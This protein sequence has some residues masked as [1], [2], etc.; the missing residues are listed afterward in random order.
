MRSALIA[1]ARYFI[2][3]LIRAGQNWSF[4][5]TFLHSFFELQLRGACKRIDTIVACLSVHVVECSLV[6]SRSHYW[7]AVLQMS[8]RYRTFSGIFGAPDSRKLFIIIH[9]HTQAFH[10]MLLLTWLYSLSLSLS[11]SVVCRKSG[12]GYHFY[13]TW[14]RILS[15]LVCPLSANCSR[16]ICLDYA[17]ASHV[18]RN[19]HKIPASSYASNC[20]LDLH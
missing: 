17:R 16:G 8:T 4:P 5:P 6:V 7:K 13:S 18:R 11:L 1:R 9:A 19:P 14:T 10:L 2:I 15:P 20:G 3:L 12:N